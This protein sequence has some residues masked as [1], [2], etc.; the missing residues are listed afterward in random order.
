MN[1][2]APAQ[3]GLSMNFTNQ[4]FIDDYTDTFV[5]NFLAAYRNTM[6]ESKDAQAVPPFDVRE[7]YRELFLFE[8]FDVATVE[9]NLTTLIQETPKAYHILKQAWLHMIKDFSA[10]LIDRKAR[11]LADL[12][13]L[14]SRISAYSDL[15]YDVY[16]ELS[17]QRCIISPPKPRDATAH[18]QL[19]EGFRDYI[20]GA[21]G[22]EKPT[23]YTRFQGL[24]IERPGKV[25]RADSNGLVFQV[26]P[27][28]RTSI[29]HGCQVAIVDSPLHKGCFRVMA[30]QQGEEEDTIVF[31]YITP[32]SPCER[33]RF[34]R[35]EPQSIVPVQLSCHDR[36]LEGRL[37]NIARPGAT[38]YL[39]TNNATLLQPKT[40]LHGA[41]IL[42]IPDENEPLRI[43]QSMTVTRLFANQRND[44]DAHQ[45]TVSFQLTPADEERLEHYLSLRQSQIIS[46]LQRLSS[47]A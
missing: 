18:T 25:I 40:V 44:P 21:K 2:T 20:G 10:A 34:V 19:I 4:D 16:F 29:L 37:V 26:D 24:P 8:V 17:Q 13:R 1:S 7:F 41:F 42:P 22:K 14:L 28:L 47:K 38:F 45:L 12:S 31:G 6:A 33:Q 15:A 43:N 23:I 46:E 39:R 27:R 11:Q 32:H 5:E 30:P 35:V 36:E 3:H 9:E